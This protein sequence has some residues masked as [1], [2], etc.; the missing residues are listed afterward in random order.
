MPAASQGGP[1]PAVHIASYKTQ[2]S[3]ERGWTQLRRAHRELLG[4][5]SVEITKVDLGPGKGIFYRL[6]AGPLSNSNAATALC[7]RLKGRRQWCEP[8]F[9]GSMS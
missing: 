4:A 8:S 7:R 9:M 1:Q 3:A 2:K 6:K 5:L